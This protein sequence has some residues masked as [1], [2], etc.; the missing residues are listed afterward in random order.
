[1]AR[2]LGAGA[3]QDLR[4]RR[5]G[6]SN[7]A[8]RGRNARH[9][10]SRA[11][12]G[13]TCDGL[14]LRFAGRL[15]SRWGYQDPLSYVDLA[16]LSGSH[17]PGMP[18]VSAPSVPPSYLGRTHA[19]VRAGDRETL[20]GARALGPDK[21]LSRHTTARAAHAERD[22]GRME[23]DVRRAALSSSTLRSPA[24][25]KR[26]RRRSTRV[27]LSGRDSHRRAGR[28]RPPREADEADPTDRGDR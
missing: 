21:T 5:A 28:D 24:L 15:E 22:A 9:W 6:R 4:T 12:L 19:R 17:V 23:K 2:T 10:A 8:R 3:S 7:R 1:M 27:R 13:V 11:F 14:T 18:L 26:P 16:W 25:A 20:A